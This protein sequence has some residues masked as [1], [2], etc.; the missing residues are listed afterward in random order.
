MSN[1]GTSH[2][3][4]LIEIAIVLVILSLLLGSLLMPLAAQVQQRQISDTQHLLDDAKLAITGY[5]LKSPGVPYLPCPDVDG[6]GWEDRTSGVCN[7]YVGD[8][9]FATLGLP[10]TDAWG[11]RFHYHVEKK[12]ADNPP[13]STP[14]STPI[15][16]Q[17]AARVTIAN[18]LAAIVLSYGPNG[19]GAHSASG[20]TNPLP[21]AGSLEAQNT[22]SD[23]TYIQATQSAQGSTAGEFDDM[24][25]TIS[26]F[27]LASTLNQA[28]R[29]LP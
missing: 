24:V 6:N 8:L 1:R 28:G 19:L 12:Y 10:A 22:D 23:S 16:I 5:A 29:T 3:F 9:P 13:P 15:V 25:S 14:S 26:Q 4:T 7:S 11:N 2:G 17:N 21:P 27:V 18:N 20:T